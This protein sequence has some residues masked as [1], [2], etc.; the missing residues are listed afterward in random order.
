MT[1]GSDVLAMLRP[2]GGWII[3]DNDFDQIEWISCEPLTEA[4]F[5]AGFAKYDAWKAEQETAKAAE[6]AALLAK[7]G[8]TEQEAALLLG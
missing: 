6:K 7:L 2:D 4:E 5:K 3:R 8:I 1:R